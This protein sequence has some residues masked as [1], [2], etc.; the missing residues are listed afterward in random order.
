MS[1]SDGN[2][3]K[4]IQV[5]V[6]REGMKKIF[7]K[8]LPI[9]LMS[10]LLVGCGS[11]V[12]ETA[13]TGTD[14]AVNEEIGATTERTKDSAEQAGTETVS[15]TSKDAAM[16]TG[17][18]S[19]T[20]KKMPLYYGEIE[21]REDLSVFYVNDVDIPY[22]SID[23]LPH[24]LEKACF[25]DHAYEISPDGTDPHVIITRKDD[26]AFTADFDFDN[27]TVTFFDYD[28]FLRQSEDDLVSVGAISGPF[29]Y[30]FRRVE[31]LS[32]DRYGKVITFDLKPYEIDLVKSEKG[33]FIPLHTAGDLLFSY[34]NAFFLYN[35][36]AVILTGGLDEPLGDIYYS[37]AP[38]RTEEFA[39]FDYHEL[40][41]TFDHL[42]GLKEIH[43]IT[44]FDD[45]FF[46]VGLRKRLMGT[47]QAKAD[48]ALYK[49]ITC[50]LDDLH[51]RFRIAS[52]RSDS[53]EFLSLCEDISGPWTEKFKGWM[54][55]FG[56]ER[57]KA[58]PD[59]IKPYEEVGNTAF[60][61]F[62]SFT[63]PMEDFDYLS[64]PKEEELEDTIRLM[65]YSYDR[66][67]RPDSPVKNVVMDLSVNTGGA[68]ISAC[69]VLGMYLG[70]GDIN[71]KNTMTGAATT[72]QYLID[73]NRDGK[74]DEK[75]SLADKGLNLYCLI[76]PVS[77]SC[78]NLV[79]N[80]F[81][82]YPHITLLG[83]T[84]GGGSCSYINLATA[85]GAT[86]QISGYRRM[87]VF[88]NGSFYDIDR[89]AEPDLY[90]DKISDFYD[91]KAL[92]E[93]INGLY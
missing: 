67:M 85:G 24:M 88:K 3:P 44:S 62:D 25:E 8:M 86:Y 92:T 38:E 21:D 40:C 34:Y 64:E 4:G 66:I 9:M 55:L 32:N 53:E 33:N 84:S 93:Y 69:Y 54:D 6:R 7:K 87:S 61:T 89:G 2:L 14:A 35:G 31:P 82:S 22:I 60:I 91:R 50:Y 27:D 42:Y 12:P 10:A 77:F 75:D 45:Y 26:T 46:E 65:Q 79:P 43:D 68:I 51:S 28:A 83:K 37:A 16:Q 13:G 76:S 90:I 1:S 47:D 74:F 59:G 70:R 58:Y 49:F 48:A 56:D 63:N 20:E 80:E 81:K 57:S 17:S 73:A 15:G 5:K 71:I 18:Y 52:N 29:S 41:F 23:D 19:I 39:A 11:G 72:S 36:E 30:L 78:G